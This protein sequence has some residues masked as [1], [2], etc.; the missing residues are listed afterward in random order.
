MPCHAVY[1]VYPVANPVGRK[2]PRK[3]DG[4]LPESPRGDPRRPRLKRKRDKV[5]KEGLKEKVIAFPETAVSLIYRTQKNQ[6]MTKEKKKE[7]QSQSHML[8]NVKKADKY[9]RNGQAS[10]SNE[11]QGARNAVD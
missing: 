7:S 1:P 5:K 11:K 9:N 3:V 10:R 2:G 8:C 6:K 4:A